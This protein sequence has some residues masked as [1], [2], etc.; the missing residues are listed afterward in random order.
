[1]IGA[2]KDYGFKKVHSRRNL[3][4]LQASQASSANGPKTFYFLALSHLCAV[5]KGESVRSGQKIFCTQILMESVISAESGG[6]C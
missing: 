3:C 2:K 6:K 1:M 4:I 5:K